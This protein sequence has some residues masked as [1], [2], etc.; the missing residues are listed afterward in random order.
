[1]NRLNLQYIRIHPDSI[2]PSVGSPDAA[3]LDLYCCERVTLKPHHVGL[4][5]TG[6]AI[7]LPKQSYGRIAD[8]SSVAQRKIV[9]VG[10]VIDAD[11]RGEVKVMLRN[12]N[13]YP[14]INEC[15][16]CVAQLIVERIHLMQPQE[17]TELPPTQRG[18]GGFGS[19]SV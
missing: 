13:D 15:G 1:M 2:A 5:N 4:V 9:V 10:G 16:A 6:V 8:R 12:D 17:V 19:T 7:A 18:T 14:V 3:G 11:Y